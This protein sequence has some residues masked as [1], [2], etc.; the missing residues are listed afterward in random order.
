MSGPLEVSTRSPKPA[1]LAS[2]PLFQGV[3]EETLDALLEDTVELRVEPNQVLFA[4]GDPAEAFFVVH[5]GAVAVFRDAVGQPVQ[6]LAR[7]YRGD[8]FGE[9]GLFTQ[10]RYMA[11]VRAT[12]PSRILRIDRE[13]FLPFVDAHPAIQ[14]QLQMAAARRHSQSMAST[15][16]LGRR[17]EVRIRCDQ[18]V[19]VELDDGSRRSMGLENLS[20]GGACLLRVP[21][22][23]R[24]GETV[25][26]AL[27][28]GEGRLELVGEVAWRRGDS[29]GLA[30]VE[31]S[32]NHDMLVQMAIR[33]IL[34][35]RV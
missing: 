14:L 18:D 24:V 22:P 3:E 13:V 21:E 5:E 25:R 31:R 35:E 11:S 17:R 8:F 19:Q 32:P 28:I 12:E 15:L 34:E 26:F 16:E 30:F 23:W 33:L 9:L 29:V 4:E 1:D 27:A 20:L 6:L 2:I 7:L 10:G